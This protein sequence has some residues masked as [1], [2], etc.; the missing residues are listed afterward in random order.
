MDELRLD[1]ASFAST[2]G[3]VDSDVCRF[4]FRS[5]Q[6]VTQGTAMDY[7]DLGK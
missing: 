3:G 5:I 7:T 6:V 1:R 4:K 2:G